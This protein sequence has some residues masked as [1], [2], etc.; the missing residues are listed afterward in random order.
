[1]D[2]AVV[3]REWEP[4]DL[5]GSWTLVEQDQKELVAYKRGATRLGFALMLK[6]FEIE[7]RFPRHPNE[8]PPAVIAYVARQVEVEPT[9]LGDYE[10]TGS[11]AEYHRS[12]IR[13]A[14]GFRRFA[15]DDEA[16]L[17][18]WLAEE[19]APVE[20]SDDRLREALLARCR[21]ERI[22]PPA[23]V[24]RILGAA[25]AAV[26]DRF[27]TAV[28][29]RLSMATIAGLE[30]LAGI[31]VD[32]QDP[33]SGAWLAELKADPGRV[34]RDTL[35]G[36]LGKLARVRALGLPDQLFAG[37]SDKLVAAWRARAT[38]EYPSDLR[39]HDP[40]VRLTLLAALAWTQQGEI[41]DGLVDLLIALVHKI[42]TRAEQG[43]QAELVADLHRV[44]GKE[45]LLFRLAEAALEHP[46]DTVRQALYPVVGP[47]T[48]AELVRE[49]RASESALRARTRVRLRSSYSSYYRRVIPELL[50]ALGFRSSN[51]R[52]APVI[53]ALALMRRYA[54]RH[55]IRY[56][57]V[58]EVVPLDGIVPADWRTAVV[59][60]REDG[61][62]GVERIPYELCVLAA[63]REAIRRREVWVIGAVRWRNPDIDLPADFDVHRATHYERLGQPLDPTDFITGL[64]G[65]LSAALSDLDAALTANDSGGVS[66]GMR[67]GR[68]WI[69]VPKL[70]KQPEPANLE[71]IKA[72]VQAR[73]GTVD[74][75]DFLAEAD[76]HVGLVDC[77]PSIATR[78]TTPAATLR[79]RLLL[80]LFALGTN[81]GIKHVADGDHGHSEAALRH[82]RR[83]HVTKENLRRAIATLVNA[84]Y[85]ARDPGLWGAG[86]A[87]ASD[88]KKFGSWESNLM[89]EWHARYRGPGVMIYW[90][91]EKGRLCVYSQLKSCSSSEVA[92][93]MEG[94]LH[95]GTDVPIEANYVDTHGASDIG[96]AFTHLLGYSLLP[97]LKNIGAARL[98]LPATGLADSLPNLS[99]VVTR[100][101]RWEL[102]AQQY[103]QMVKFATA[104][105]LRTAE[106]EQILRRFTRPGPQHPTYA[107]LVELGRAVKSVFV[108]RYLRSEALRREINDGLQVVE[109]WN[110][111]NGALFYGKDRELTGADRD[112]QEVSVLALHLLQSALVYVN[113]L[114]LQRILADQPIEL[115]VEDR[116][117]ISPLFW[118]HVRPYGTFQLHLDR[119]LDLDPHPVSA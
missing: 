25:R 3:R 56:Y 41:I 103:D 70:A 55:N 111:A 82:V 69:T 42:G 81:T 11:T 13:R 46:D 107:A 35:R 15:L 97:R 76:H 33:A 90:H 83:L 87:C 60:E 32:G 36:E 19:I 74:L 27:T 8:F 79:E 100:P 115:T 113:T 68:P 112:S 114:L 93:M 61:T 119:H 77:F 104:L 1:M 98:Y 24:D 39:A 9:E 109:N 63:L 117:A 2:G 21:S 71:R 78:E 40:A 67:A 64:R 20:L 99:T 106:S 58:D 12:Q 10:W 116:R 57:A 48:L 101:I 50:E 16:K 84:N 118:T 44:R 38:A 29:A 95:H 86:T 62:S 31:G 51:A 89:T 54:N 91:V 22:E 80:V 88:S 18:G 17:A 108:A 75:L 23:R 7:A 26:S 47:S 49:G 30:T 105:K 37:W 85:A 94:L 110:S 102:I 6:F 66:I 53:D 34:S 5:V 72:A 73:W 14:M 28:M 43:A 4:E 96:F 59:E 45:N 65:E 52:H 92:A